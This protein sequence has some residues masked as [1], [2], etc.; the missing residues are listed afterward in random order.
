MKLRCA[1][2]D[3]ALVRS[4]LDGAFPFETIKESRLRAVRRV[5]PPQGPALYLKLFNEK[6]VGAAVR[7]LVADRAAREYAILDHLRRAGVTAAVPVAC[8]TRDGSSFLLTREIPG[9]EVLKDRLPALDRKARSTL[10]T[11]LGRFVRSVHDAG[12]RHDD[13]HVGNVLVAGSG[14]H[15]VDVHRAALR[16]S[17]SR[18]E[19][20]EGLG[21][22]IH[23]IH[24]LVP[25][26]DQRRFLRGYWGDQL[27]KPLLLDLRRAFRKARERYAEDRTR[28]CLSS[29]REFEKAG[30]LMVRRPL[31]AGDAGRLLKGAALRTV[32]HVGRRTLWLVTPDRFVREGPRAKRIWRNAHGLAVRHVATPRLWAWSGDRILGEWL[33]DAAPLNEHL[34]SRS[35]TARDRRDLRDRL[36]RFVREMHRAGVHHGDLKANNILVRGR[37]LFVIDLDRAEFYSEVPAD[38][39]LSD[40]VQ[41]NAAVGSPATIGDRLA[42]YR[43]YAGREAEWHRDEKKRVREIMKKTRA[44]RHVWPKTR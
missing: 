7:R 35:W 32:K 39:R 29:G 37:D 10:V 38:L 20:V 25:A 16:P 21:F 40:L 4:V 24:T 1:P 28:R 6:G 42:F 22:L 30:G 13:L 8:G 19:R 23:S 17:L 44:R 36:A 11:S 26:G 41:L 3:E 27:T 43:I 31:N 34:A 14:L 9:A 18:S 15:L 2:E 33:A 5:V 12:V